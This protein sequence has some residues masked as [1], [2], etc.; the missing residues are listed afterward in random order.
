MNLIAVDIGNTNIVLGV[1]KNDELFL[2]LE[3]Y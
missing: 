1:F 2:L 3:F